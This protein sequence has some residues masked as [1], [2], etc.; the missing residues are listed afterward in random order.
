MND[1]GDPS[2]YSATLT[3]CGTILGLSPRRVLWGS[4]PLNL[5]LPCVKRVEWYETAHDEAEHHGEFAAESFWAAP[6]YST[7][8]MRHFWGERQVHLHPGG[9][10]LFLDLIFVGVAFRVGQLLKSC[11]YSCVPAGTIDLADA[12]SSG[13]TS[14]AAPDECLHVG[15]SVLHSLAPFVC[16]YSLWDIEKRHRSQFSVSSKVHHQSTA[17]PA[18]PPLELSPRIC[19]PA[20]HIVG[21]FCTR[22]AQ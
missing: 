15:L 2:H 11:M 9:K 10:E 3:L 18:E 16:M 17:C 4:R 13:S 12:S 1:E 22:F 6:F 14:S 7:P 8:G 20:P 5:G 19:V 21:A